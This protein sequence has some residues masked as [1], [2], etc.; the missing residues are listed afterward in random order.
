[1]D[2]K[3]CL[4]LVEG[5]FDRQ[6]LSLLSGLFDSTKLVIIP[7]GTDTLTSKNYYLNFNEKIDSVL[8][9]E[10]TYDRTDFSEF[11]QICDTDGCFIDETYIKENHL[12]PHVKYLDKSIEVVE[13]TG[14]LQPRR[15]KQENIN[16]LLESNEIRLF[17][18]STN[19]DH[20]FDNLQ[21]PTNRQKSSSALKMYIKYSDNRKEFLKALID[22]CPV[23]SNYE[24]S[25]TYVKTGFNSLK[26]CSNVLFFVLE[27]YD[28]LLD[29]YKNFLKIELNI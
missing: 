17:Y 10:K 14:F 19:I 29:E 16:K 22:V 28:D 27:H 8:R 18:N 3:L 7:F 13:L 23:A 25:W 12:I 5:P 21:N 4:M 1:M 20:V 9:K 11:V 26:R 15:N 24:E 6:R 2:R